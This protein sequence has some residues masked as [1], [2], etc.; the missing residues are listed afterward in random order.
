MMYRYSLKRWS[1]NQQPYIAMTAV[2]LSCCNVPAELITHLN[3]VIV[4]A[5][6][7][8]GVLSITHAITSSAS[9]LLSSL[10]VERSRAWKRRANCFDYITKYEY[11]SF[12]LEN[13]DE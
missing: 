12:V 13:T 10:E 1:G 3:G 6:I 2:W 4:L 11:V 5:S 9:T 8:I 7:L